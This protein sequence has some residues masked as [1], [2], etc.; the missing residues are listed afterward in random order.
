MERYFIWGVGYQGT[1]IYELLKDEIIIEAF[2][3][4]NQKLIGSTYKMNI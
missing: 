4:N 1:I 2:I 3:D